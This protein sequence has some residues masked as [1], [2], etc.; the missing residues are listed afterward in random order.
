MSHYYYK[1]NKSDIFNVEVKFIKADG[2]QPADVELI[3]VSV[4]GVD[5]T[6]YISEWTWNDIEVRVMKGRYNRNKHV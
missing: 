2:G 1:A 6:Q 4:E 5:I 3:S